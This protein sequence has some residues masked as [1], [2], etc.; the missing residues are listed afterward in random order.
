MKWLILNCF[1]E[2]LPERE[3]KYESREGEA[4]AELEVAL[5]QLDTHATRLEREGSDVDISEETA[6]RVEK[7]GGKIKNL[8][9]VAS[10]GLALYGG[11]KLG[12]EVEDYGTSRYEITTEIG[13]G[14]K[15]EYQHEDPE[16]TRILKFL[17]GA[18]ELAPEDK[19]HF[20][21]ELVRSEYVTKIQRKKFSKAFDVVK[22]Y[23]DAAK[24]SSLSIE[25][26][27]A[28]EADLPSNEVELRRQLRGIYAEYDL[29]LKGT[30]QDDIDERVEKAFAESIQAAVE[31]NPAL[32]KIVWN[33]QKKV[34]APRI[35]WSAPHD[36]TFSDRAGH[37]V[38]AGRSMYVS[39]DNTIYITPGSN[40]EALGKN[41]VAEDAHALQYNEHPVKSRIRKT[42]DVVRIQVRA[43]RENKTQYESQL[44]EYDIPGSIEYEAHE[45]IEKQLISEFEKEEKRERGQ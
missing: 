15:V 21:R 30:V 23:E 4:I 14:G 20:Y 41:L 8:L 1:M 29:I 42:L 39:R 6:E 18:E 28:L 45:E 44:A 43:V 27:N 16:T 12:S 37:I 19:I 5:D 17:T 2:N 9:K 7:K 10:M 24:L 40:V 31:Y 13:Q 32:E 3:N 33:L 36:N 38:G 34:G 35:R 26:Y 22:N 11:I 25:D